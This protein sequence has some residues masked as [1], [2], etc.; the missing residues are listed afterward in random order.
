MHY[1]EFVRTRDFVFQENL[2]IID[3]NPAQFLQ[4]REQT[5]R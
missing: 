3:L 4:Y 2:S 5:F 1:G